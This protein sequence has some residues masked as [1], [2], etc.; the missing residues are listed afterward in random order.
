MQSDLFDTKYPIERLPFEPSV[1]DF[2]S[3]Y[4]A[5][6]AQGTFERL[7]EEV[8]WKNDT[9]F[10]YGKHIV[11]QRKVAWFGDT[12][13]DYTYSNTSRTALPW[14]PLLQ[15]I[16]EFVEETCGFEYNSVLLNLYEN[17]SEGMG[18]HSD[19]EKGL[20]VEPNIASLS[21]GATRRFDLRH[22]TSGETIKLPLQ[23]GSLLVMSKQ[24]QSCWRHQIPK[25]LRVT[26]PRIN[27]TFRNY[28]E[29]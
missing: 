17:G 3:I 15:E 22:K 21:F 12:D 11:T 28:L 16:R 26:A 25:Q 9:A 29:G 18:W 23:S 10:I 5:T 2:G 20:G 14:T 8:P 4:T 1:L 6:K 7:Y 27:L 13:F 19:D 24:S